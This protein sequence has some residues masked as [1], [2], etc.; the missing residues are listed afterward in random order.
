VNDPTLSSTHGFAWAMIARQQQ[1]TAPNMDLGK[2]LRSL[3]LERYEA[4][5][6]EN[7]IDDAVLPKLTADD[8][9]ELGVGALGHRRKLLDAIAALRAQT[10]AP[11]L[12]SDAPLPTD[13]AAQDTAERRQ[14]TV[15]FSDL[16]GSTSLSACMD[17]E[18]LREVI[19]A[20]QTCVADTVCRLGGFVAKYMGDGVLIYFGYPRAHEDDAERAVRAGLEAIAAVGAL[21]LSIPLKTRIGIATGLVVIGDLIGSGESQERGIT[22][23]TPNVAARLQ[24]LAEPNMVVIADSTRR[25]LGDLFDLQELGPQELKGIPSR[26]KAWAALRPSAVEGRF[27]ALHAGGLTELIGRQEELELLLRRWSKAK[28]GQGQMVLLSGEPGIGKSR[29]TAALM[30]RLASE[31]HTRLRYFCSPQRTDSA[32]YPIISQMERAAGFAHDDRMQARLGKIDA[33]LAR[34]FTSPQDAALLAEMLSLAN[35]GRYPSLELTAPQRRQSTFE[36]LTAQVDALSKASPVL[37]IFEDVHWIDPTSL[38]ALSRTIDRLR[39][40]RVLLIITYRPEFDP[41]WIERSYVAALNLNRLGEGEIKALIDCVVGNKLL[42]SGIRQ[43]IIERTD[44]IPLFVEEMTKAVMEGG[45]AER[46]AAS[47]PSPAVAVPPSLHASLMA[48]L[49]RLGSTAKELAQ[50]GAAI[51]REFS[52]ELLLSVA[53][54]NT[55]EL[56]GALDQLVSAELIFRRGMPPDAEYTFKHALVQ[57]A[58]YSTLLRA[59]RQKLHARIAKVLEQLFLERGSVEPEL[60]AHHFTAAGQVEIAISYWLKAGRSAADRSA[61]EEAVRHLRRGLE[62]LMALP[63]STEKDRQELDFQIALGTPL[64]AQHGYGNLLVGTARDRA[65]A[66][67]EKLGDTQHLLPTLYGQYAYCIASGRI[68]KALEYSE[69][70]Q[71]LAAHTGDRLVRLIAHRAM[72]ASLLEIGEFE[73]AT[74]QLEEI[75]AIDK[76]EMDQSLSTLYLADPHASGLTY[77]A[78]SRW[79]LGYPDQAV[80]ARQKAMKYALDANH[81]NTSGIV[82]IYAGAQLSALLGKM[83]DVKRFVEN[84][85]ARLGSRVPHWATSCGQILRGWAIGCAE[86]PEDGIALMK[87]GIHAA[88]EQVRFHSSHYHSLLAILQARAGD[89]QDS[90]SAIRKAKEL[91]SETG[92]YLWHA[93]VLRIEGELRRLFGAP[94]KEAEAIFVQA[95]EVARKQRAKSFELRVAMS[96]TRLWRDQ[97]KRAEAR[98]LLAPV[99]GWFTEG[100]DTADLKQARALLAELA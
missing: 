43:D 11:T 71:S 24:G 13:K 36:A 92:E 47:I 79:A 7:E 76:L 22:G 33:L 97:G 62:K 58:A 52:Y 31:P 3:G 66:L 63:D 93:D 12:L 9:R 61:D 75:L 20:Y 4:A 68:P 69:R 30:E 6:R 39:N 95:F 26:I 67:C 48:R 59:P 90:L 44:G 17:P 57:D 50:V 45:E 55:A 96:M 18:D 35:D 85:D 86:Q 64:A 99:Y 83:D 37:M 91:M 40:L 27:E 34:S 16:V 100:F 38:E 21:K 60:L 77:L 42:P 29:L 5:F 84:L 56:N 53:Q 51:G 19:S 98:Q 87:E 70:C 14:V 25:L 32:L 49:D 10:S 8:L 80:A 2:W 73:A 89:M 54:R 1:A 94:P 88:E 23:E 65:I 78:L 81:A 74:A 82:S 28:T 15:M 72:G 46:P 41:P